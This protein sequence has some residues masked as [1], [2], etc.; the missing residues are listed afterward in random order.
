MEYTPECPINILHG[1]RV[2]V[3]KIVTGKCLFKEIIAYYNSKTALSVNCTCYNSHLHQFKCTEQAFVTSN[4]L[5][6]S[7][8]DSML[9]STLNS[10][11]VLFDML[12]KKDLFIHKNLDN[13]SYIKQVCEEIS[14]VPTFR[15]VL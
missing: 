1:I 5:F 11:A 3:T 13:I 10:E 12:V 9:H 7:V 2:L 8:T 4:F 15:I 14:L 6:L